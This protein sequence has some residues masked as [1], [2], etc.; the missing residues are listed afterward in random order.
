[1]LFLICLLLVVV[2]FALPNPNRIEDETKKHF[3]PAGKSHGTRLLF[4]PAAH[5]EKLPVENPTV[6]SD[7]AHFGGE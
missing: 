1:M 7:R 5:A 2:L 6:R 4:Q 3:A